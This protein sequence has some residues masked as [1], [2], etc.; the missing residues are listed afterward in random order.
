MVKNLRPVP[1][2]EMVTSA[3]PDDVL[4]VYGLGSCVVVC[5]HDPL[6]RVGGILHALLP[7]PVRHNGLAGRPT[8]FVDQGLPLLI[9]A[10]VALGAKPTRLTAR[11][12]GGARMVTA[13]GFN[14]WLN[15]GQKNVLAA[16]MA[17]QAGGLRVQARAIGGHAGRTVKFYIANG[18]VTVRS[19][20]QEEQVLI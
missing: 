11:L 8:K 18:R 19:L 6:V 13:P 7:T 3:D 1:V 16:E 20:E 10:L 4:V 12:C 15:I 14:D 2:G 17:L 9:E 5:L